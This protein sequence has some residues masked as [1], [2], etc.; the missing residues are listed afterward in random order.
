MKWLP[1]TYANIS[2]DYGPCFFQ[3][4][5]HASVSCKFGFE[6][7]YLDTNSATKK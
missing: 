3:I 4:Y 6:L 5:I 1:C 7:G 2:V